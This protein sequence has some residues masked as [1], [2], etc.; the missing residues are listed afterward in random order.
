MYRIAIVDDDKESIILTKK[1][2]NKFNSTIFDLLEYSNGKIFID[3]YIG[4]FDIIFL[5]I[6]MP[7]M[8]GLETASNI[9]KIDQDVLIIFITNMAHNAINGYEVNA[10]DFI[11][12]PLNEFQFT[13]KLKRAVSF[14][15]KKENK[16][17]LVNN[18]NGVK[19]VINSSQ[20]LYIEVLNHRL[21]YHTKDNDFYEFSSLSK[22]EKELKRFAFSRCNSCFLVNLKFVTGMEKDLVLLNGIR[23]KI[24]RNKKKDFMNSLTDFIGGI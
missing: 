10:L 13:T 21:I 9:R 12:K 4:N 5:D 22:I 6:D 7:Q 2:I 18:S 24:S 20:V 3:S 17:L 19:Q 1:I 16:V 11:L 15:K 14:I 23:L 8:D